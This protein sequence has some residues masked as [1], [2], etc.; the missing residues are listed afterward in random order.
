MSEE[1]GLHIK[2]NAEL[3]KKVKIKLAEEDKTLKDYITELI[4]ADL[5]K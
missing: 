3:L 4:K 1:K 2:I 5:E